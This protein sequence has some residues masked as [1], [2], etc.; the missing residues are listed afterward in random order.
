MSEFFEVGIERVP[1]LLDRMINESKQITKENFGTIQ[2]FQD[3]KNIDCFCD[4]IWFFKLFPYLVNN[5]NIKSDFVKKMVSND[6]TLAN[7]FVELIRNDIQDN[8]I[9]WIYFISPT[10]PKFKEIVDA[11]LEKNYPELIKKEE[12]E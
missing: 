4:A 8:F 1:Y 6:K 2:L 9:S 3:I 10:S 12:E 11:H 5:N 7:K